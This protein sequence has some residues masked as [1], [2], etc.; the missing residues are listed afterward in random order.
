M[1]INKEIEL[2]N[3]LIIQAVMHGADTG[4]SYDCNEDGLVLSIQDW[5]EFKGI[6]DKYTVMEIEVIV[7]DS[8]WIVW[9]IVEK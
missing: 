4:G 9:Q 8:Y 3:N 1:D 2:V 5:V 6:E 7:N